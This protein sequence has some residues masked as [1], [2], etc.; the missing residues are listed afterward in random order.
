MH[1]FLYVCL[2]LD[3]N[4]DWNKSHWTKI[5][6]KK[7][8]N[9]SGLNLYS[10]HKALIKRPLC[11]IIRNMFFNVKCCILCILL[12][13]GTSGDTGSA[14]MESV[15]GLKWVDLIVLL[16]RG[17]TAKIQE[18][19]MTTVLEDNI[20]TF[21]GNIWRETPKECYNAVLGQIGAC[22]LYK[23]EYTARRY[24]LNFWANRVSRIKW[25]WCLF[26]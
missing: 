20:H 8:E 15:R 12:L 7:W 4:S 22:D 25:I 18:L 10:L 23:P 9:I 11:S 26:F 5:N 14:A 3:Q 16:P 1:H 17:R 24:T 13:L 2:R 6:R 21:R 19:Q